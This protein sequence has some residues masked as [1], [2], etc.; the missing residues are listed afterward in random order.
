MRPMRSSAASSHLRYACMYACMYARMHVCMY[1]CMH[2]CTCMLMSRALSPQGLLAYSNA[3]V[4]GYASLYL[5]KLRAHQIEPPALSPRHAKFSCS[6][7]DDHQQHV[8]QH[9]V[10]VHEADSQAVHMHQASQ[11]ICGFSPQVTPA[12]SNEANE[13]PSRAISGGGG[14][15]HGGSHMGPGGGV[16]TGVH[17]GVKEAAPMSDSLTTALALGSRL[18]IKKISKKYAKKF[19]GRT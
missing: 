17:M 18:S 4:S 9:S 16:R 1:A 5:R 15:S 3:L 10:P 13:P 19:E 11:L 8:Q 2:V 6:L 14:S 12:R 7:D